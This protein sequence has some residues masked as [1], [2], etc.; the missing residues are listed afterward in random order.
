MCAAAI[1]E[2]TV[3][4]LVGSLLPGA[5]DTGAAGGLVVV[6]VVSAVGVSVFEAPVFGAS[7]FVAF[8]SDRADDEEGGNDDTETGGSENRENVTKGH[9]ECS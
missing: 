3:A 4:G 1:R 8:T 7:A 5:W 2:G 6:S 9:G